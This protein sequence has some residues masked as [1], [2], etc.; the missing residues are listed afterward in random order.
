MRDDPGDDIFTDPNTILRRLT[1][2]LSTRLLESIIR[3]GGSS[4][5][6]KVND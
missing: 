4:G 2:T 5:R 3:E 1:M 6:I